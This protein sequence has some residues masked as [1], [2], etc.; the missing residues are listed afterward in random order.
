MTPTTGT[1][2]S[3]KKA[4][5]RAALA[6]LDEASSAV[7]RDCFKQFG[8]QTVA[9]A[10]DAVQRLQKEKFEAL[11]V[12]LD[13]DAIAVLESARNSPSNRRVVIYAIA[14]S[15]KQALRYSKYG[16]NSVV[17]A[18]IERQAALRVV[19]ATHLLVVHELRRYV[20]IPIITEAALHTEARRLAGSTQEISGGGM[21]VKVQ[22]KLAVGQGVDVVF[23][24]PKHPGIRIASTVCWVREA[25][26]LVGLRFSAE[27][28]RRL[29]V[30]DW[31]DDYLEI[32]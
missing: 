9:L 7:L 29:A 2:V 4:V 15:S 6:N 30:K 14:S 11:V 25:A 28:E 24:L 8:I 18:P 27:D 1:G 13:E 23:D 3:V 26:E 20:R 5:A 31:I 17:D 16:I 12:R 21:S 19:R 32:S 10:H 22:A